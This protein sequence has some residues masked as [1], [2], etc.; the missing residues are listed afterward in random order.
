MTR[1]PTVA[2]KILAVLETSQYDLC[3][4]EIADQAKLS[5]CNVHYAV[6]TMRELGTV[7][8][9]RKVGRIPFYTARTID[10]RIRDNKGALPNS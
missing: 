10:H 8:Q 4:S 9:T 2:A 3:V 6:R 5:R 7:Q 1:D